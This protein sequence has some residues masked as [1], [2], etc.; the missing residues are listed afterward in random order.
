V[1]HIVNIDEINDLMCG[2][3]FEFKCEKCGK[4]HFLKCDSKKKLINRYKSLGGLICSHCLF[5]NNYPIAKANEKRKKWRSS[6]SKDELD[7]LNNSF[8]TWYDNLSDIDKQKFIE[9]RSNSQRNM[10]I[11]KKQQKLERFRETNR[12]RYNTDGRP[13]NSIGSENFKKTMLDKYHVD[14]VS[15]IPGM[16]RQIIDSAA[17]NKGYNNTSSFKSIMDIPE[18][19]RSVEKTNIEKIGVKYPFQSN[20]VQQQNKRIKEKLYG[21]ENYTNREKANDT[22]RENHDGMSFAEYS[23]TEEC[24]NRT[25]NTMINKYGAPN[26]MQSEYYKDLS[27]DKYNASTY[28]KSK[29]FEDSMIDR[30]G[31][32]HPSF[33]YNYYG[34]YFDSSWE[35]AVWIY[36]I[37]NN[38]PIIRCP[39]TLRY[40][41]PNKEYHYY[42]PDFM[43]NG[44]LVEIKGNQFVKS[45]G[46]HYFPY[47]K[48]KVN[49]VWIPLT[50]EEKEYMDNLYE[51]RHHCGLINGVEYWLETDCY[52]Y[53]AYCNIAHPGWNKIFLSNN[54]NNPSYSRYT[55]ILQT[56]GLT[57]YDIDIDVKDKYVDIGGIGI[58]PFDI[59]FKNK[60][61][62]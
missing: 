57:P 19:R 26:I 45:D 53:I 14:H 7:K 18:I 8:K 13:K 28:F 52:K 47:N 29:Y 60:I 56:K 4:T 16:S 42:I 35:L 51:L 25:R 12:N 55:Y 58:T 5:L 39:I 9:R 20:D 50:K 44:Q 3:Y 31:T 34:I 22:F 37:D 48:K 21:D 6:L 30:Y 38:I 27:F 46:T 15:K 11:D 59:G 43:I 36:C 54:P 33:Y 23:R 17:K 32:L 1:K 10:S 61:R 49:G 62:K 40:I 2:E 24:R 41:G